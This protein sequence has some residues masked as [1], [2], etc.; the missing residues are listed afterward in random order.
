MGKGVLGC[1]LPQAHWEWSEPA[2]TKDQ[3]W[4]GQVPGMS[5]EQE[6]SFLPLCFPSSVLPAAL[7]SENSQPPLP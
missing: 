5:R 4:D 3:A 7:T 1:W 2:G 6:Q